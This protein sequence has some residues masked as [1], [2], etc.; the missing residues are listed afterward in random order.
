MRWEDLNDAMTP[1]STPDDV[2]QAYL[3][4]YEEAM[5]A[6]EIVSVPRAAAWH[7][8]LGHESAGLKHM[9]EVK[10]SDP[11]WNWDRTRYRGRGPIQLTWQGN[12]RKFGKWCHDRGYIDDPEL[13]VNQPELVEQPKW[14]FLAASWYWL[15]GGPRPGQI[16]SF[17]DRGDFL[18]V[19]RCVNGWF[20]DRL[21]NGWNDDDNSRLPRYNRCM[22]MGDRILAGGGTVPISG[23]PFWLE[24]VLKAAIGDRLVV[25]EGWN[26]RGTGGVMGTIWGSMIHHTGND[27]ERVEVIRDGVQQPSGWLPGP[28]SQCLITRDGKCHLIAVGPCN[29]AGPGNW[30]DLTDGNRQAIGFECAYDGDPARWPDAMVITMRDCAAAVSRHLG[31][32]AENSV[33]G[34]K[35][36]AKPQGRKPDPANFDM[37]WFRSEVNKDLDGFVFPGEKPSTPA[38]N[39][40]P[41]PPPP[42]YVVPPNHTE[43]MYDQQN[44]RWEMLGWQTQVE[45]LA[46]IRDFITGSNDAGK[47]GF[48]RGPDPRPK[49]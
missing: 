21:P 39:P 29:H 36:Y 12:Y 15:N 34:H 10:T 9:A 37:D 30:K 24:P 17:A 32:R 26:E 22:K 23:D 14:G 7:A 13:F 6:A 33:C 8:T 44:G 42:A 5:R 31:K 28:L 47:R 41:T 35:E 20:E 11:K 18:A 45:A 40:A 48:T 38:P 4:F 19:S 49:K 43:L 25:H 27:N 16:N 2:L 46:E 3:P 1:H